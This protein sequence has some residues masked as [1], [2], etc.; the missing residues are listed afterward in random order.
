MEVDVTKIKYID[1]VYRV[2]ERWYT[3]F[4]ETTPNI[5]VGI[6]VFVLILMMSSY[7][8]KVSVKIFHRLF[9]NSKSNSIVT[10]IGV[11]KFLIILMGAFIAFEIMGLGG[12]VMKFLGSLG[13]AGVI[14]GVAL[15]DLVSSMFS[16]M[17][18]SFDK[19]FAVGDYVSIKGISGTVETIG[20]LTTKV[21]TDEGKKVYIP[22]Q[23]IFSA[24]FIN[25]SASSQRKIFIDLEIPNNE[26]LDKAKKVILDEIHT[27]D[28]ADNKDSAEVI[29]LKQ[30]LGIFY[31]EARF[32][33]KTGEKIAHIRS[34]A[35]LRIKKKLDDNGIQLATQ[36]QIDSGTAAE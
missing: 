1:I 14:A 21:I 7:L 6:I 36:T 2:L 15:K 12:F 28:F 17:L 29:F 11:F 4:A 16:G 25:Y 23:L 13:V 35:L 3:K 19:A 8:S 18:I 31:L 30:S 26:D 32:Q 24:P 9:P 34:E 22:N 27:F 20:F 5:A 33:M 10:L